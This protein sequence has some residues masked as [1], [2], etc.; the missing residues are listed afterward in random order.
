[1]LNKV[2]NSFLIAACV[3]FMVAMAA[4]TKS[5]LLITKP[6]PVLPD[7]KIGEVVRISGLSVDKPTLV[8]GISPRCSGCKKDIP[9]YQR[10]ALTKKVVDGKVEVAAILLARATIEAESFLLQNHIP[11][12]M[13]VVHDQKEFPFNGTPTILLLDRRHVVIGVWKGG[14]TPERERELLALLS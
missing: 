11:G 10:V 12:A 4:Y 14:L 3:V 8:L 5:Q 9:I 1:M 2:A 6:A 7:F 13:T